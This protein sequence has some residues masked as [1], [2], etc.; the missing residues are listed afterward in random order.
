MS[1]CLFN[2]MNQYSV[3]IPFSRYIGVKLRM[4][5]LCFL[6]I[7][8][9]WHV[10]CLVVSASHRSE[11]APFQQ[12]GKQLFAEL[13]KSPTSSQQSK[14]SLIFLHQRE[15]NASTP[16]ERK[17]TVSESSAADSILTES[18]FD[19]RSS[20]V[21]LSE[22]TGDNPSITDSEIRDI[23]MQ[24]REHQTISMHACLPYA[25]VGP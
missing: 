11:E 10:V 5:L 16:A 6:H 14:G 3:I 7:V 18:S 13:G 8:L 25:L 17:R 4:V 19:D 20:V 9:H 1:S 21:A 24:G 12:K 2:S 23:M 15:R 22:L